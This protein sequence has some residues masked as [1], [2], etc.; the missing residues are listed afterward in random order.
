MRSIWRRRRVVSSANTRVSATSVPA[1]ALAHPR[2]PKTS[3]IGASG[4]ATV[5]SIR[6]PPARSMFRSPPWAR[7]GEP[8]PAGHHHHQLE[9]EEDDG[10]DQVAVEQLLVGRPPHH[11]E[12]GLL[13][14]LA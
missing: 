12:L 7:S 5:R 8:P 6:A 13:Q 10:R 4:A 1:A 9:E 3:V 2:L 11:L 14:R